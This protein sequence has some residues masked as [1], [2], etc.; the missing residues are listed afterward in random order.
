MKLSQKDIDN[1]EHKEKHYFRQVGEPK[2]L[3]IKVSPKSK[4]FVL[5]LSKNGKRNRYTLNNYNPKTFNLP[6]AR[7]IA[8]EKVKDFNETGITPSKNKKENKENTLN[9][10]FLEWKELKA[11]RVAQSTMKKDI[12]R[13][14]KHIL[15]IFG[16]YEISF[17]NTLD[18]REQLIKY[19]QKLN[20]GDIT[21]R[22]LGLFKE[23]LNPQVVLGKLEYNPINIIMDNYNNFFTIHKKQ[24]YPY[25]SQKQDIKVLIQGIK[26]YSGIQVKYALY[27]A[28]LSALRNI[29]VRN[30]EWENINFQNKTITI[31]KENM[32][33]RREFILPI[34]NILLDILK[35]WKEK[36]DNPNKGKLFKGIR[37]NR[38][39]SENALNNAIRC[40][41]FEKE[42][43][44]AHGFRAM[45]RTICGENIKI[46]NTSNEILEKCLDHKLLVSHVQQHYDHSKNINDMRNVFDW[47]ANYLNDIEPLI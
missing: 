6:M 30:L 22:I 34:S 40:I 45:F 21:K 25:L 36:C 41:G 46:I 37:T 2:E 35:E 23:L 16:N 29:N 47:Y 26:E 43:M 32:K 15:P 31:K 18:F 1:L 12:S 9:D 10:L 39:L 42:Q 3:Y 28:L 27:I 38:G 4:I 17:F 13:V 11:Q 8:I 33:S 5:N 24:H 44:V 7:K 14:E 20:K 19:L